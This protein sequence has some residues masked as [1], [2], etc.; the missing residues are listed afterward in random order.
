MRP[1]RRHALL[2]RVL[3]VLVDEALDRARHAVLGDDLQLLDGQILVHEVLH[4]ERRPDLAHLAVR[5][6]LAVD[7]HVVVWLVDRDL[8]LL[9]A[10]GHAT[11][12]EE[13]DVLGIGDLAGELLAEPLRI[14]DR[15]VGRVDDL[16]AEPSSD[17]SAHL[18]TD[19][20]QHALD[21][22]RCV[23]V[24]LVPFA[25]RLR[26]QLVDLCIQHALAPTRTHLLL[27]VRVEILAVL[28]EVV[29]RVV[30]Q[31]VERDLVRQERPDRPQR[32]RV[33]AK[34]LALDLEQRDV[35]GTVSDGAR[36]WPE[37]T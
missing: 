8:L 33:D 30:V 26:D 27:Q 31:L 6:D 4:L 11:L 1:V 19:E 29:G 9:G 36:R 18:E 7:L 34:V 23:G 10:A 37:R 28:L 24:R 25:R 2:D 14:A 5:A 3:L 17:L 22:L 20:R 35:P 12:A 21:W 15:V 16:S 13:D 32:D